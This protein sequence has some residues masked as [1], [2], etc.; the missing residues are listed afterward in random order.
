MEEAGDVSN[1]LVRQGKIEVVV[2]QERRLGGR[3]RAPLVEQRVAREAV[4]AEEDD[5]GDG[6]GRE[7]DQDQPLPDVEERAPGEHGEFRLK[8]NGGASLRSAPAPFLD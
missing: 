5:R 1:V 2:M 4:D 6:D 7:D 3:V 8:E